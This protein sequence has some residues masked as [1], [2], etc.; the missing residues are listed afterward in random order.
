MATKKKPEPGPS[1]QH[2]RHYVAY[3]FDGMD[4]GWGECKRYP[5]TVLLCDGDDGLEPLTMF[6]QV[7]PIDVCGELSLKN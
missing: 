4:Q 2:C 1:C 3:V 5:P 7:E 6:P